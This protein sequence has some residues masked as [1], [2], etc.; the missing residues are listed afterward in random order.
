MLRSSGWR[1]GSMALLV[2]ALTF[3]AAGLVSGFSTEVTPVAFANLLGDNDNEDEQGGNDNT[4]T[5][6]EGQVLPVSCPAERGSRPD[7]AVV[8]SEAEARG[9]MI[10]AELPATDPGANPPVAHVYNIDGAVR[11]TFHDRSLV[12]QLRQDDYVR[13]GGQRIHAFHFEADSIESL[14]R[15]SDNDNED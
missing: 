12:E 8:C 5:E 7:V 11:V 13:L 2:A 6:L 3:G 4:E 9:V 1:I 10:P 15:G 14:D